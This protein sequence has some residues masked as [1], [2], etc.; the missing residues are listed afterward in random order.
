MERRRFL[1]T[2]LASA[3]AGPSAYGQSQERVYR[4][5]VIYGSPREMVSHLEKA[6]ED[7][8][9]SRDLPRKTRPFRA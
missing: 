2:S 6:L 7:S 4:I 1:L 9:E 3:V 8:L 5:A